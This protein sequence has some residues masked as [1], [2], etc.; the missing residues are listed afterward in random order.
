LK[1]GLF[2]IS[3]TEVLALLGKETKLYK[4]S[5]ILQKITSAKFL[6]ATLAHPN[7][8]KIS[9]NVSRK[10]MK[11]TLIKFIDDYVGESQ[12]EDEIKNE[13]WRCSLLNETDSHALSS[14]KCNWIQAN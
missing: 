1:E 3:E 9:E 4:P 14:Y 5:E 6:A 13:L 8:L 7:F 10:V 12:I 2:G 11:Q